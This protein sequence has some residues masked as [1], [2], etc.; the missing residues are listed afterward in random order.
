MPLVHS[1]QHC[2]LQLQS[3]GAQRAAVALPR[4]VT[5]PA[6]LSKASLRRASLPTVQPAAPAVT[7]DGCTAGTHDHLSASPPAR[8]LA[9]PAPRPLTCLPTIH[10]VCHHHRRRTH[11]YLRISLTERCNLRCQYCMPPDGAEL[12]PGQDLL[13]SQEV[14]RLVRGAGCCCGGAGLELLQCAS[15]ISGHRTGCLA[16]SSAH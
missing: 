3:C 1:M 8:L 14:L 11:N 12:T 13:S 2:S 9:R 16:D 10:H 6:G 4:P 5:D 15:V 7:P